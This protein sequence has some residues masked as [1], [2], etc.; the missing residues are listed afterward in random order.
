MKSIIICMLTILMGKGCDHQTANEMENTQIEYAAMSRGYYLNITVHDKKLTIQ[1]KRDG[2]V[3]EYTLTN[4]DWKELASMYKS[5]K[6]DKLKDY[7]G[8]TQKRFYDGAAIANL[9][10]IYEGQRYETEAF[11]HMG[12]PVEIAGFVNKLVSFANQ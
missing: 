1:D 8:A 12:P 5:V 3:R 2:P 10:V 9:R 6:L 7:K 11:D 4:A